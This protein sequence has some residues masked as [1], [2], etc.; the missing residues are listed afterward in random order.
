[1]PCNEDRILI[2][3]FDTTPAF[4][5]L[6]RSVLTH[7]RKHSL[8]DHIHHA[9]AINS[10]ILLSSNQCP[11]DLLLFFNEHNL[12][13]TIEHV[14]DI[15]DIKKPLMPTN[16]FMETIQVTKDLN[17]NKITREMAVIKLFKLDLGAD[18]HKFVKA[19]TELVS[20]LPRVSLAKQTNEMD[21]ALG[22]F[23]LSC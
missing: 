20:K 11:D 5:K 17:A 7:K 2:H 6:Q 12:K 21:S 8:E 3:G 22:T 10:I 9:L 18:E 19:V 16:I 4:Y 1:S 14:E 15:Y 13:A 23:F